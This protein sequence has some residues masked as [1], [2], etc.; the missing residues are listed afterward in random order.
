[1]KYL[2]GLKES[3]YLQWLLWQTR[4]KVVEKALQTQI[5]QKQPV[6]APPP[7][8]GQVTVATVQGKLQLMS[9]VGDYVALMYNYTHEAVAAGAQLVVFP[10]DNGTHLL[11]MLPG[12]EQLD[13]Q[14]NMETALEQMGA[15]ELKLAQLFAYLAPVTN[16]VFHYTFSRLAQLFQVHIMPGSVIVPDEQ[17]RVVNRAFL[18][19]DEGQLVGSQTKVHLLPLEVE[20]GLACGDKLAVF[21]TKLGKI[22]FPICM[23]A[24]YYE[25]FR[26]LQL[27]G[28]QVVLIPAANPDDYNYYKA[29]RGIW[30]RVQES[31]LYGVTSALV[32]NVFGLKL[33]GKTG[34]Y[35]PMELTAKGDG[36][37]QESDS[38]DKEEVVVATLDLTALESLRL[39]S[40]NAHEFN[41]N[42]YQRHFPQLYEL[43][44]QESGATK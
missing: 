38:Y 35:A 2:A 7:V 23:D 26:I 40:E 16:Q 17:G 32:G 15:G 6:K 3:L 12:I 5:R 27:M 19:D 25:T 18:Y 10:E 43:Y 29:L 42:L 22:A 14:Q 36:I 41:V 37:V 30:P 31:K 21:P 34:I 9:Q 4:K 11:G 20:W 28:A 39:S 24:T 13:P 1:M 33:T 8:P 44:K